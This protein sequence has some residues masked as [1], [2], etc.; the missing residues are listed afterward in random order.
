MTFETLRVERQGP[1]VR[2]TCA[3]PDVRNALNAQMIAELTAAFSALS[4]DESVR[5]VVLQG[6]GA[7]FSGGADIN[8]MRA[9]L[10]LGEKENEADSLRL[11]D[12]FASI[13][14]CAP[15]VIA[16]VHGAALGGG[17]G[18]IAACDI[19]I[20]ADDALF[21]FTEA[22]LGIVPAVI[23]PFVLRKTGQS[24]ARALFTTGERFDAARALRIGLVHEVVPVADLDAAVARVIE[25]ILACGPQASRVAKT[26]VRTVS[27]MSPEEA[28]AW[29]AQ[30]N[31][32][33][34]A[35]DEGQEGLRAFLEKR[36]PD[37]T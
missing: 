31:A 3:R 7:S 26:I 17:S 13:D 14:R 33:R 18:I 15:P 2:V 27:M 28:R 11:S 32:K 24:H 10:D 16:R 25:S 29:T 21:G 20:A 12:M 23:S 8:Y 36:K 19:V 4:S 30:M 37:W 22:R 9:S 34:R 1:I 35:S 5:A 6:D